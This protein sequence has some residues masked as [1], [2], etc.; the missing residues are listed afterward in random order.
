MML[1]DEN[2]SITEQKV[3]KYLQIA[4]I[5]SHYDHHHLL[6]HCNASHPKARPLPPP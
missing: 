3:T 1:V 4:T 6:L 2:A 5:L